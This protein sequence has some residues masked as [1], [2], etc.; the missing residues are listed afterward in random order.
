M[1]KKSL[2]RTLW[3]EH[4]TPNITG[5]QAFTR[6][7]HLEHCLDTLREGI[8]CRADLT[9]VTMRWGHSQAIPHANFSSPHT[10]VDWGAINDWLGSRSIDRIFDPGYLKHPVFGDVYTEAALKHNVIV[11]ATHE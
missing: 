3:T 2:H 10:C 9:P 8:M 11:G 1:N 7:I 5:E 4:Y 6:R